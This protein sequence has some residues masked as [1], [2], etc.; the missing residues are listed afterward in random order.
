MNRKYI[1]F[2]P[3]NKKPVT[4]QTTVIR[5]VSVMVPK[6]TVVEE[7]DDIETELEEIMEQVPAAK[8]P[9]KAPEKV[10]EVEEVNEQKP[11]KKAP[12]FEITTLDAP[13]E[14]PA[15][16]RPNFINSEKIV[17]RP[18]SKSIAPKKPAPEP[19]KEEKSTPPPAPKIIVAKPQKESKVGII[20]AIALTV[21]LGAAVGTI[22]FLLLP[23]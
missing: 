3:N 7:I 13:K 19:K 6:N 17:K 4:T 21:V 20:I 9:E 15:Y 16:H 11:I 12:A 14:N 22:A 8:T 10:Q 2:V 23:K 18:L 5:T 1:D